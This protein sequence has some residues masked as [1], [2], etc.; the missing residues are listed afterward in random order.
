[1]KYIEGV[2]RNPLNEIRMNDFFQ[3]RENGPGWNST[4]T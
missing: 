3:H 1:M 4:S 2:Q